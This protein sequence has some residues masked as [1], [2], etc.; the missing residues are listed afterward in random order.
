MRVLTF[1]LMLACGGAPAP[2]AE[3]PPP[4]EPVGPG[5]AP[6]G[7]SPI[8]AV[9]VPLSGPA[10]ALG[11]AA[12]DGVSLALPQG[13]V[14]WAIDENVADPVPLAAAEPR[15]VG[16]VAHVTA[17]GAAR[18]AEGWALTDL[19]VVLA[20][21][22]SVPGL[23]RVLAGAD[24]HLRCATAWADGRRVQIAHDGSTEAIAVSNAADHVL[25]GRSLGVLAIDP[26][27][28]ATEAGHLRNARP[29][30]VLYTGDAVDGGNLLR[31]LRQLGDTTR[32][33]GLGLYDPRFLRAAG[34]AADGALV[35]SQDR[36]ALDLDV[37]D[38]WTRAHGGEPP[39]VALNA[40]DAARL[41][42]EAWATA[43]VPSKD[44]QRAAIT[45]RLA[46]VEVDGAAGH[47]TLDDELVASPAWCTAFTA[48]DGALQF[49]GV[50]RVVGDQVEVVDLEAERALQ[51]A[52]R[53][54]LAEEQALLEAQQ[55]E[56]EEIALQAARAAA[57]RLQEQQAG[58]AQ[59]GDAGATAQPDGAG[60]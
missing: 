19:P 56:D 35:T 37:H 3:E 42:A 45:A 23:P 14:A 33:V 44:Q 40:Y 9:S 49:H 17:V 34:S 41:L 25:G 26:R 12:V 43:S 48:H 24:R 50:A 29:D 16:V 2:P 54:R 15:V 30:V 27:Q 20:A 57:L 36:P 53:Q 6:P 21:P 47:F 46:E 10:A 51:E 38:A 58:Q 59:S 5:E 22:A 8:I 55:R 13:M 18:W 1:A 60:Q 28:M 4:P 11:K 7:S 52:E 39:A 32:F 31:A